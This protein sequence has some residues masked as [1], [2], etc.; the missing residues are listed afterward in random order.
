MNYRAVSKLIGK[1]LMLISLFLVFPLVV[2]ILYR[3]WNN[4]LSYVIPSLCSFIIGFLLNLVKPKSNNLSPVDSMFVVITS[5][6]LMSLI[7]SFPLMIS[8]EISNFFDAF[9]EM[10]SGFTTTGATITGYKIVIEELS[11]SILFLRSFSHWVGGMGILVLM[12]AIIPNSD[13]GSS[14]HLLR[15]ESTGPQVG[16]LVSK[17]KVS[18]RILYLI[19]IILTILEFLFL[20]LGPDKDMDLFN[21]II[22]TLGTAGTG[23]FSS[24]TLSVGAFSSY[25]QYVIATFM[26]IFGV[27]FSLFYLLL[28][29]NFKEVFKNEELKWYIIIVVICVGLVCFNIY[30]I[31]KNVEETI[32]LSFFQVSSI[33]STTGYSTVDYN[34]WP[35]LSKL[36]LVVLMLIGSCAGSTAG[37]IKVIRLI[38]LCKSSNR[39]MNLLSNP[40]N[41]ESVKINGKPIDESVISS[42]RSFFVFY[43]LIFIIV[44]FLISFDGLD[45]QTNITASIACISNVGPGLSLVGPSGTYGMFSNL[46]KFLLSIEMIA[47]RLEIFP[48]LIIFSKKIWSKRI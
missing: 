21:S 22:H 20:F 39:D 45:M 42:V 31:Y 2:A 48:F 1:I 8:K 34:M 5:W 44:A 19:Y 43:L 33:I 4:I 15:A 36:I 47:G 25:S 13:F 41:I 32:R 26:I 29:G 38:I 28:L 11:H 46:S 27:N 23:G 3:E 17:T 14:M 24:S 9:F 40:R 16:K 35:D 37:G 7:C 30:S 6:L 18:S 12:L 10:A